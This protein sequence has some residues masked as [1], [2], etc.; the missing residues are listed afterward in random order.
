MPDVCVG[1]RVVVVLRFFEPATRIRAEVLRLHLLESAGDLLETLV[2]QHLL[3]ELLAVF[4]V[5][6]NRFRVA[7][8]GGEQFLHLERH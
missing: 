7:F 5:F 2:F 4:V 6:L 3:H 8:F 1:E